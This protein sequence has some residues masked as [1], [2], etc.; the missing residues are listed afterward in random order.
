VVWA[1]NA[2]LIRAGLGSCLDSLESCEGIAGHIETWSAQHALWFDVNRL[3]CSY[4]DSL[5]GG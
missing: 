5:D 4:R 2:F 3:A 1:T